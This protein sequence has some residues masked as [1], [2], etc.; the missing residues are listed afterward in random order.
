M[1]LQ[2]RMRED[3]RVPVWHQEDGWIFRQS[4]DAR[5]IVKSGQGAFDPSEADF[6]ALVQVRPG[7]AIW[8]V[9][10]GQPPHW[11]VFAAMGM[12]T[13]GAAPAAPAVAPVTPADAPPVFAD[14]VDKDPAPA[15]PKK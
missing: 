3:G 11:F 2:K 10:A 13:P 4:I 5:E 9:E 12:P 15:K 6:R 1:D 14:E 8:P 7:A